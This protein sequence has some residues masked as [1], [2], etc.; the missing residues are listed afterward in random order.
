MF[1]VNFILIILLLCFL[2]LC[3]LFLSTPIFSKVPFVPVSKRVLEKIINELDLSHGSVLYDLGCG[4]GRVLFEVSEK[5]KNVKCIG[6]EKAPF[7]YLWAKL[8]QF[9]F[10][11]KN[12]SIVYGDMFKT[13]VSSATHVFLYL[14]PELM[15]ILLPKLENELKAGTRV[16]SCDF[17]FSKKDHS[18]VIKLEAKSYQLNKHLYVYDF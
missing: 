2:L 3:L 17:Q 16:L 11:N 5:N 12:V 1:F 7:P 13:D 9:F 15:D 6:V 18:K 8:R 4:E 10:K 14:F